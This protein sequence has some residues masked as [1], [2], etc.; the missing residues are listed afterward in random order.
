M[1]VQS[2]SRTA[3]QVTYNAIIPSLNEYMEKIGIID[4]EIKR[5]N[6]DIS[7]CAY[8]GSS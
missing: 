1:V 2:K 6:S 5:A 7:N 4:E 3:S 8:P